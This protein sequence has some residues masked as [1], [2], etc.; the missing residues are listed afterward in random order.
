MSYIQLQSDRTDA[1]GM[2]PEDLELE[3]DGDMLKV[4]GQRKPVVPPPSDKKGTRVHFSERT[5]SRMQRW[6]SDVV[7]C[8]CFELF[9]LVPEDLELELDGDLLKLSGQRKQVAS[10]ASDKKGT[11]VHFSER[12]KGGLQMLLNVCA[13]A[14][15][16]PSK[17]CFSKMQR[18]C[19]GEFQMSLNV[20]C[21]RHNPSEALKAYLPTPRICI[22]ILSAC[23]QK[24]K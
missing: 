24:S 12:S 4:S 22:F 2:T 10:P 15:V 23:I 13:W 6:A 16:L 5:Y 1:P 11:R 19:R 7:G 3:L 14:H 21:A 17:H 8:M 18:K 9:V 20:L